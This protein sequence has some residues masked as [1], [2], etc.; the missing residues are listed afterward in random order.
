MAIAVQT[1]EAES[2]ESWLAPIMESPPKSFIARARNATST[3]SGINDTTTE[4]CEALFVCSIY[5]VFEFTA[6]KIVIKR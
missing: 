1:A 5:I 4:G 6:A 2:S 3:A